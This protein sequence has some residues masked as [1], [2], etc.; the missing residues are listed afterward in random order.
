VDCSWAK[1]ATLDN[2][3]VPGDFPINANSIEAYRVNVSQEGTL[4]PISGTTVLTIR[5]YDHQGLDTIDAV[6]IEA[7]DF[8]SGTLPATWKQ[9]GGTYSEFEVSVGNALNAEAG[10]YPV[11][12][13]VEDKATVE[14]IGKVNAYQVAMVQVHPV[15][16]L[17]Q[18]I[19]M[20]NYPL[21]SEFDSLTGNAYFGPVPLTADLDVQGIGSDLGLITGFPTLTATGGIG[22]CRNTH[23]IFVASDLGPDWPKDITVFDTQLK[24]EDYAVDFTDSPNGPGPLDFAVN[25]NTLEVWVS[26]FNDNQVAYFPAD[27]STPD[28][29]RIDVPDGPTTMLIDQP[30]YLV[31]AICDTEDKL[32]IIDGFAKKATSISLNTP[33]TSPDPLLP[34]FP[35]MAFIESLD[36]LYIATLL[37][38]KLDYYDVSDS[39][40]LNTIQVKPK[41]E[42]VITGVLYDLQSGYLLVTGQALTGKGHVYA[43]DPATDEIKATAETSAMNPTFPCMDST[44]RRLFVPDPAGFVDVFLIN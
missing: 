4:T 24:A 28:L 23:Q 13:K 33:V 22:M 6:S 1:P 39:A 19:P 16:E 11:L 12:V 41:D 26:L 42:E 38:G 35:G 44:N 8:F 34:A 9:D 18:K 40:Y 37:E 17:E 25:E 20:S 36:R 30:D 31:F 29:K 3:N 5:V 32:A 21:D 27:D 43:I 2:P 14:I 15:I 7:P 10:T